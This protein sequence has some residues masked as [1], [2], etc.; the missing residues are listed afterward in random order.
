M[1]VNFGGDELRNFQNL[2]CVKSVMTVLL[3]GSLV[4]LSFIYP[5]EYV[6][7]MKSCVTMVVTFYFAHQSDKQMRKEEDN[8]KTK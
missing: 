7:T 8:V 6:E 1:Y 5:K 2:M 4:V 3:I